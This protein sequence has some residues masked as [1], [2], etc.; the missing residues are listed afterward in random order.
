MS[1]EW[2]LAISAFFSG[3]ASGLLG[4]LS[5]I[6]RPML[7]AKD[8]NGFR[9]FMEEFRPIRGPL[10]GEIGSTTRG[11]SA[12]PSG[13][14][15]HSCSSGMILARLRFIVTAIGLGI[16]V[17][18]V[19][20]V[21]NVWKTPTYNVILSWDGGRAAIR[22]AGRTEPLFRDQLDSACGDLDPRGLL[23]AALLSL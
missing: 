9:C 18:G 19:L 16:V 3:L 22:L 10:T 6:M 1:E 14:S 15:S 11:R 8:G 2:V 17:V 4:M 5:T 21:S 13:R 23:L 7:A 20:V 12:G